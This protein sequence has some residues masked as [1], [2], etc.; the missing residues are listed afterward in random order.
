MAQRRDWWRATHRAQAVLTIVV[1]LTLLVLNRVG[2]VSGGT[3]LRLFL[4]IELPMVIALVTVSVLRF[5]RRGRED[6]T[7]ETGVLDRL[8]A[9]EP[10]L[11]P[12]VAELRAF[13][14]LVLA[15]RRKRKVPP[16][17]AWFG[18]TRG[19]MAFPAVM[20]G[21]SIVELVIAHLLVPWVWLRLVMLV[22]TVWG[23][24]FVCGYF[25]S[26]IVH[27]HLVTDETLQ[28]RWGRHVVL[29]TPLTNV[30]AVTAHVN[31]AHTQPVIEGGRLVLTQFQSTNVLVRFADPV[32][33]SAPV[34]RKHLPADFRATEVQ[35]YVDAPE[36]L[37]RTFRP[38][39]SAVTR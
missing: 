24:L 21:V 25:A 35:L 32:A 22:L 18:Y 39:P 33:A 4:M 8:V 7:S 31:H 3:A 36:A 10:L 26:R 11:R 12:A 27:P 16:G 5:R 1:V 28:L 37:L 19:T 38:S 29:T 17:A 23:V 13:G 9:E 15:A 34:P 14:S 30:V 6:G 2:A 20:I